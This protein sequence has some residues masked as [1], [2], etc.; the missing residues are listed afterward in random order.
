MKI[1]HITDI[2]EGVEP[3]SSGY[4]RPRFSI[5]KRNVSLLIILQ[6]KSCLC[7]MELF[8]QEGPA[9]VYRLK[10]KGH[11]IFLDLKLHDIPNTVHRA[12]KGL[13]RMG[14]DL[15][16]VHAAGGIEMMEAALRVGIGQHGGTG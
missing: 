10:E 13:A 12:M 8:Y 14:V 9:I 4:R 5:C 2:I 1:D 7:G 3:E 15:V 11:Q 6:T 16:T